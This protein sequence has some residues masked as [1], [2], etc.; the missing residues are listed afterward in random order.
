M[1]LFKLIMIKTAKTFALCSLFLC[2]FVTINLLLT[3]SFT[4]LWLQVF[5]FLSSPLAVLMALCSRK[6]S[7]TRLTTLAAA[8]EDLKKN[9]ASITTFSIGKQL[10]E[11]IDYGISTELY[12]INCA[13]QA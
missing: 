12:F 7:L 5:K 8:R 1:Y 2:N 10:L 9:T 11:T 3:L 13:Y 6:Y 4:L